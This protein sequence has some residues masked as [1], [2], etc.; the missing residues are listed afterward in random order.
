M[1]HQSGQ[2]RSPLSLDDKATISSFS[3][4]A[5]HTRHNTLLHA[6][7]WGSPGNTRLHATIRPVGKD[8][9]GNVAELGLVPNG[10]KTVEP[11]LGWGN[12]CQ[13]KKGWPNDALM[14]T[15]LLAGEEDRPNNAVGPKINLGDQKNLGRSVIMKFWLN[16]TW[17]MAYTVFCYSVLVMWVGSTKCVRLFSTLTVC[18]PHVTLENAI[19]SMIVFHLYST[20]G[21]IGFKGFFCMNSLSCSCCKTDWE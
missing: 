14:L 8:T 21:D 6:G 17:K 4:P 20:L 12:D 19:A 2:Q 16:C 7:N 3:S 15:A 18:D 13:W 10:A 5:K 1:A 9:L 11:T